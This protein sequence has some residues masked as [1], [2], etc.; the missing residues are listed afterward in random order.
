MRIDRWRRLR[1]VNK[2]VMSTDDKVAPGTT[3]KAGGHMLAIGLLLVVIASLSLFATIQARSEKAIQSSGLNQKEINQLRD[4]LHDRGAERDA[5]Q[6]E[7]QDQLDNQARILCLAISDFKSRAQVAETIRT[8]DQAMKS[9]RCAK[10][11]KEKASQDTYSRTA[12][13]TTRPTTVPQAAGTSRPMTVTKTATRT[14]TETRT[15]TVTVTR[16]PFPTVPLEK[17]VCEIVPAL[18]V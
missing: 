1:L 9:L 6:R 11:I 13:P 4:F 16:S 2:S 8:L 12:I 14:R 15:R 18:C 17:P 5:Q 7:F 10:I 3:R